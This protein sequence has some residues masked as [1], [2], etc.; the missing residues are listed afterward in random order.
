MGAS[1]QWRVV[2]LSVEI[3]PYDYDSVGCEISTKS[4]SVEWG[5]FVI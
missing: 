2:I 3:S 1:L 5:R 4:S